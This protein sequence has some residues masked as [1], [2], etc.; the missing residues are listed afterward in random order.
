VIYRDH[1]RSEAGTLTS[2]RD[3]TVFAQYSRGDTVTGAKASD[4]V[5]GL[6]RADNHPHAPSA[7]D[8]AKLKAAMEEVRQ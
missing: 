7:G 2:W 1:G 4:L 6:C 8:M 3:G 5:F